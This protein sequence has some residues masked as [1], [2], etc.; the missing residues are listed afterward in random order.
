MPPS[1]LVHRAYDDQTV[2]SRHETYLFG[3]YA[4]AGTAFWK[5]AA[6]SVMIYDRHTGE[7]KKGLVGRRP[8]SWPAMP[9]VIPWRTFFTAVINRTAVFDND[10]GQVTGVRP[11]EAQRLHWKADRQRRRQC[12][13]DL[14]SLPWNSTT[15]TDGHLRRSEP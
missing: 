15:E 10:Q 14:L 13:G 1:A 5:E 8:I 12:S 11:K 3:T 7:R 4:E 9:T 6:A 2:W